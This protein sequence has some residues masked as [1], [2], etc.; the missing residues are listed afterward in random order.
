MEILSLTA[1]LVSVVVYLAL[2]FS[3]GRRTKRL[4]DHLPVTIGHQ[5]RVAS[6]AE[7]SASTVATTISLAT[8]VLAFF[9]LAPYLGTWLL[10]TVITTAAGIAVVRL[11]ARTI[12]RRMS[13]YGEHR[14]TLHE[15]LGREYDSSAVALVGAACTSLGFL[16]AFAVELTVGS[17]FLAFLLPSVPFYLIVAALAAVSLAY[18]SAGGFRAVIVTDRL[19]MKA[20]WLLLFALSLFYIVYIYTNGG[21]KA[22]LAKI[23]PDVINFSWREG[24]WAFLIG[25]FIINVPTFLSDMSVWQRIAGTDSSESVFRGLWR[26]ITGAGI[27]WT[28]F[29]LLACFVPIIA[30]P[31]ADENPLLTLLHTL[32]SSSGVFGS[33]VLF[34]CVL[35]LYGAMFSTASTQLVAVSHTIHLDIIRSGS[36]KRGEIMASAEEVR[37]SRI[38]IVGAAAIAMAI[39]AIL[40]AAGF[41]IA[42]LIFAVY[43][44]QLGLFP[45]TILALYSSKIGLRRLAPW[46][47]TAITLG[48]IFGW[49]CAGYGKHVEDSNL[50]F[51]APAAS[52]IISSVVLGIGMIYTRVR[53]GGVKDVEAHL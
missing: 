4:A 14:P 32:G 24:L 52:L 18:T 42:D 48:F 6:P 41:S 29:A 1:T 38:L 28:L 25:I 11:A 15:F 19:Q 9:E 31:V 43:G 33:V 44:A 17:R 36:R 13:A 12:L 8:V 39:V 51:L 34:A 26:S 30:T 47:L 10:W 35:G 23:P 2:G 16:G 46:A 5:A 40:T 50:V 49:G 20:I 21:L 45:A 53:F 27:T 37:L 22:N 3:L 7:F